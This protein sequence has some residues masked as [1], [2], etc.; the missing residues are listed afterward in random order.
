LFFSKLKKQIFDKK[1]EIYVKI[2][3][4]RHLLHL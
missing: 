3:Y 4:I 2:S 1:I